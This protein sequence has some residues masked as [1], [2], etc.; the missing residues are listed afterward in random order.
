[1]ATSTPLTSLSNQSDNE[2]KK[3]INIFH[4]SHIQGDKEGQ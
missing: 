1:M 3:L 4:P 2:D